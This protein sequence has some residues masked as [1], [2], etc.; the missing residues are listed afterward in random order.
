MSEYLKRISDIRQDPDQQAAFDCTGSQVVIAGPGSGKTYLLT[1][2]V[3]RTLFEGVVTYPHK[4]ACITFSRQLA[5]DLEKEF[6]ALGIH[7][8]ERVYVGTVH[9]FCIAEI[10]MPAARLLSSAEVPRPLRIASQQEIMNALSRALQEQRVAFPN[11]QQD[12]K[13]IRSNL[14]KFRRLHFAPENDDFESSCLLEADGYS[15]TRLTGLDWK[16]LSHDYH[17]HLLRNDPPGVDFV[18]IEML[19]LRA[20]HKFPTLALT[21]SAKYPWWFVDE[22][23]DLSPLFHRMVL[24]LVEKTQISVFAIG[25]P[26]Q[27]IYEEL[28]GSKPNYLSE[29]AELVERVSGNRPITLKTNYRSAQNIID[30]GD[31]ILGKN[32]GYQSKLPNQGNCYAVELSNYPL[33]DMIQRILKKLI[34]QPAPSP[35]RSIAVLVGTRSQLSEI[36]SVLEPSKDWTVRADKDPDFDANLELVEWVQ[37]I[38]RW[39]NGKVHF[40]ELLPFWSSL[41]QAMNGVHYSQHW[42]EREL[43]DALWDAR[44][45]DCSLPQW[46]NQIKCN[47]L[48]RVLLHAYAQIRPDDVEEFQQLC[49]SASSKTRLSQKSVRWFGVQE[50]DVFLTTFHSSKGLEFDAAI[51]VNLDGI[52]DSRSVPELKPRVAYVAVSRAKTDLF[53]LITTSGGEFAQRLRSQ[54]S[55]VLRYY[56]CNQ[57]GVLQCVSP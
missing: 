55:N 27:C 38:A 15:R 46:I 8:T 28:H 14:E 54:H 7:D 18:Y 11:G 48:D 35:Q 21:L 57:Y 24:H 51:V 32:T 1:T 47:L 56:R 17:H 42:M 50:G 3:A 53:I 2:K 19:A 26:N 29:L 39:C 5:A 16:Q 4:V 33:K 23:Q 30:L 25:D 12:Q 43:F 41:Y 44:D 52:I 22:Y 31:V 6:W 13:N 9:S 36:L 10:V 40:H 34:P 20:L 49:D 45:P 37:N